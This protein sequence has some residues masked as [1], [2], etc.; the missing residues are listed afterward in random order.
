VIVIVKLHHETGAEI[1]SAVPHDGGLS[2]V[3]IAGLVT[4]MPRVKRVRVWEDGRSFL[5]KPSA[6]ATRDPKDGPK[7]ADEAPRQAREAP[8]ADMANG[9]A[10][11]L[12]DPVTPK[13][14][15]PVWVTQWQSV[16][17]SVGATSPPRSVLHENIRPT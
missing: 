7:P 10:A 9:M 5:D 2:S 16:A 1:E 4:V 12:D 8:A 3:D 14:A 15:P 17:A 13:L 11:A 6:D